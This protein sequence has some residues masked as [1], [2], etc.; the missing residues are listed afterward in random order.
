MKI[1]FVTH[2]IYPVISGKH[3]IESAG[4]AELQ[5]T[6]LGKELRKRGYAISYVSMD[7]GQ[8]E[9]E[10]MDGMEIHRTYKLKEGI[11]GIRFLYPMF[12]KIWRALKRT[13]ADLYYVR[14]AGYLP[15]IVAF[16]CQIHNKKMIYAGAHDTDFIPHQFRF[17]T[18]RDKILYK[19]G[20][21]RAH[22]IIAQSNKQKNLLWKH[23]LLN[24]TVIPNFYP[25]YPVPL[26]AWLCQ[27]W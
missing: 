24:C 26:P 18:M 14:C 8:D 27:C 22:A 16:F 10:R 15:G 23:F 21:R 12:Y 25:F 9:L 5:Q 2:N 19:Y 17:R 7:I 1:C 20:L 13:N 6:F 11:P 4:G 3:D